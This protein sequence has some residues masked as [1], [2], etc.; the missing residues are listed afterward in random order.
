MLRA[1]NYDGQRVQICHRCLSPRANC[2]PERH[3]DCQTKVTLRIVNLNLHIRGRSAEDSSRGDQ[4]ADDQRGAGRNQAGPREPCFAHQSA[5]FGGCAGPAA[6]HRSEIKSEIR[7]ANGFG[8]GSA[9]HGLRDQ[10]D[11]ADRQRC[12]RIAQNRKSRRV[13]MVVQDTNKRR[14]IGADRQR[15]TQKI[16]RI[17]LGC[18]GVQ[19]C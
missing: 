8:S 19:P 14:Y 2:P 7:V 10:Q 5:D 1:F 11:T 17:D 15:I 18:P 16:T 9:R 6:A 4:K 13:V 12:P 3:L